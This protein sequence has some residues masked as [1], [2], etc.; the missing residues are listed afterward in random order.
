MTD[1]CVQLQPER[2]GN[3]D[4]D[5]VCAAA[6][7][8]AGEEA[9]ATRFALVRGDGHVNLMFATREP[10]ALWSVLWRRLYQDPAFGVALRDC[11]MVVCEGDQGWDDYRL[12]HHFDPAQS[13]D[14]LSVGS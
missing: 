8:L 14:T 9:T 4:L 12:L 1:L 11:S 10:A 7:Q 6:E 13:L 3:L 5:R 2:A